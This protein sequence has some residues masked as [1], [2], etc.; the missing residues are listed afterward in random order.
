[1]TS[2]CLSIY[3]PATPFFLYL[4][5]L[6]TTTI[7]WPGLNGQEVPVNK[8]NLLKSTSLNCLNEKFGLIILRSVLFTF[9]AYSLLNNNLF[10]V[11]PL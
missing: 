9:V 8:E 10:C 11:A 4:L 7:I 1:M 2:F 3:Q 6:G 5:H